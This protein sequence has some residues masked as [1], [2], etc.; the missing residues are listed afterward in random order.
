METNEAYENAKRRVNA[1]VALRNHIYVYVFVNLLLIIINLNE[2]PGYF[3]AKW[4]II[5][6]GIGLFFH[7]LKVFVF[8]SE[9]FS[10]SEKMIEKEMQ[11]DTNKS[12]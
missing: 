12:Y 8:S 9:K 3:W 1:K 5:G 6:W 2:A 11:K 7:A 4:P 10:I